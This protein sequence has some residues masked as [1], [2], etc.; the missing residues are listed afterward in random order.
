[1]L[2]Q[3]DLSSSDDVADEKQD[4]EFEFTKDIEEHESVGGSS[5]CQQTQY[6]TKFET[7]SSLKAENDRKN[8][9]LL[10]LPAKKTVQTQKNSVE[11]KPGL[12]PLSTGSQVI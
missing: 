4:Q 1:M 10:S 7:L 2:F 8:R 9:F 5:H 11:R 3:K 12:S 6:L